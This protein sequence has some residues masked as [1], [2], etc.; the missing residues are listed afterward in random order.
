[1]KALATEMVAN[2][3]KKLKSIGVIVKE[4]TGDMQ[5][6]KKQIAETH[7]IVSTPEKF[8]VITRKGAGLYFLKY[9]FL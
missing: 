8:D 7:V 1:M 5:L 4:L 6:T 2:F 3:S 9:D